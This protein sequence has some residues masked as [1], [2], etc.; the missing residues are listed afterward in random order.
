MLDMRSVDTRT[1]QHNLGAYLDQVAAGSSLEVRRRHKPVA[2]IIPW[3]E[4]D[5]TPAWPDIGARLRQAFPE[6]PIAESASQQLYAD[7]GD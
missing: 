4:P 3:T 5:T 2:R 7:R 1:L 6:G